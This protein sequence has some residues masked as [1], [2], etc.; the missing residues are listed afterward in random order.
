MFLIAS[1]VFD[2]L[3]FGDV[4][5]QVVQI[6]LF[7]TGKT[8]SVFMLS[9]GY[10]PSMTPIRKNTFFPLFY[11]HFKGL[12]ASIPALLA[13]NILSRVWAVRPEATAH[14]K[15][16]GCWENL[17]LKGQISYYLVKKFTMD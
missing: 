6:R 16:F 5:V 14:L 3:L 1:R 17:I 2:G 12:L 4:E 10:A 8:K 11:S 15:G 9:E 7:N 13:G